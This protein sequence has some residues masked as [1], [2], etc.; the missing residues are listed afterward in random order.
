MLCCTI[1]YCTIIYYTIHYIQ[2]THWTPKTCTIHPPK[3]HIPVLPSVLPAFYAAQPSAAS[4][5]SRED[6]GRS[7]RRP[8][9]SWRSPH[10]AT[11][12]QPA[13]AGL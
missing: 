6:T 11:Q 10:M 1:L 5:G 2:N 9:W 12:L 8:G 4:P 3:K 7:S 13:I